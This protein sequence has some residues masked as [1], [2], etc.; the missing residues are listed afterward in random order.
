MKTEKELLVQ[1]YDDVRLNH[2]SR[3]FELDHIKD[4]LLV[5]ASKIKNKEEREQTLAH[6]NQRK[7]ELEFEMKSRKELLKTLKKKLK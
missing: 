3:G 7:Q 1:I 2:L 4:Y 6:L 5:Q